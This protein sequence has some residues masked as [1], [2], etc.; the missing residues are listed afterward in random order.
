VVWRAWFLR[1]QQI[2]VGIAHAGLM[3]GK[4]IPVGDGSRRWVLFD[5]PVCAPGGGGL[6]REPQAL[7]IYELVLAGLLATVARKSGEWRRG[8][9]KKVAA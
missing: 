8:Q 6:N 2:P 1:A 9:A 7:E 3:C 5:L 4:Q